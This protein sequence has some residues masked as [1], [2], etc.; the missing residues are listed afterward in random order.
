MQITDNYSSLIRQ[1]CVRIETDW[2]DVVGKKN[3]RKA[4]GVSLI[5]TVS[6]E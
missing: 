6:V 3:S 5:D 2:A 1:L 4:E